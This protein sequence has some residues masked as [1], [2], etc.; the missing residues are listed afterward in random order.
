M[1]N[2][3]T[4]LITAV[5]AFI[6]ICALIPSSKT[7]AANKNALGQPVDMVTEDGLELY[8]WGSKADDS[9]V[10]VVGYIGEGSKVV[11]PSYIG[12]HR[13]CYIEEMAF[14]GNTNITEVEI[15]DAVSDIQYAA[16]KNCTNLK[17]VKFG[18]Y[19]G[20]LEES[21]PNIDISRENPLTIEN[22][23]FAGCTSLEYVEFEY[24]V[25]GF[26]SNMTDYGYEKSVFVGS[27]LKE[28][29]ISVSQ[30]N[31]AMANM[32]DGADQ[33]EKITIKDRDDGKYI[34]QE[35][36]IEWNTFKN[37]PLLKTVEVL[38]A[39]RVLFNKSYYTSGDTFRETFVNC[40]KLMTVNLYYTVKEKDLGYKYNIQGRNSA[41]FVGAINNDSKSPEYKKNVFENT[42]TKV[43]DITSSNKVNGYLQNGT[44]KLTCELL[45]FEIN[46]IVGDGIG[47]KKDIKEAAV[48]TPV[49]ATAY[50]GEEIIPYAVVTYEGEALTEGVDYTVSAKN[51][52]EIGTATLIITGT[53]EFGG[54]KEAEFTITPVPVLIKS[55]SVSKSKY[56]IT[57]NAN[58]Q[59]SGYEIR[60]SK[61]KSSGYKKLTATTKLT[62]TSDKLKSGI[63]I[64]IRTYKTVD[65]KKIYSEYSKPIKIK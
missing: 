35:W 11:I 31:S 24:G 34:G 5:F 13:V 12:K 16:F 51:N 30:W 64:K 23:A 39:E 28:V 61:K 3:L 55:V 41:P 47:N 36:L 57:W 1:K 21:N 37:L 44:A 26:L 17:S 54:T 63:Y 19:L 50:T 43:I 6:I 7:Q 45:P 20:W 8:I 27:G 38:N 22:E 2:T 18:D 29:V 59:A 52:T 46:V 14:M 9:D 33:L 49:A 4:K 62:V 25:N 56:N 15:G 10:N 53:G 58:P 60:Y 32:F 40:P 42:D 48:E 65:G